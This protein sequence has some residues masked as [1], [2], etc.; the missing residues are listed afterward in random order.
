MLFGPSF[1]DGALGEWFVEWPAA[2]VDGGDGAF[3]EDGADAVECVAVFG[4]LLCEGWLCG[5]AG[6]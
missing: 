3:V 2:L 4:Y 5:R 6:F 1:V